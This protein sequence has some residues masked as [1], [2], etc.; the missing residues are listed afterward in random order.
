MFIKRVLLLCLLAA[1][2]SA[3]MV[4]PRFTNGSVQSTTNTTIDIDRTVETTIYGALHQHGLEPISPPVEM[5][6]IPPPP[7]Q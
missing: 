1:P 2:A 3:Q 4:T 6:P 5:S 7:S